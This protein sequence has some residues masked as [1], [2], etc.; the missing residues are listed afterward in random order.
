M[1]Q[2]LDYFRWRK[3]LYKMCAQTIVHVY[4]SM[5]WAIF[6]NA[7]QHGSVVIWT[8]QLFKVVSENTSDNK[9]TLQ[10]SS[11]YD[12]TRSSCEDD[13]ESSDDDGDD[14]EERSTSSQLKSILVYPNSD[15][16]GESLAFPQKSEK[17]ASFEMDDHKFRALTKKNTM[18]N[19]TSVTS[20]EVRKLCAQIQL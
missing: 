8:S 9:D 1:L 19:R 2:K 15:D 16:D 5:F 12:A 13:S 4:K 3:K 7:Y 20:L 14:D 11:S 6:N 18:R 10:A 17:K